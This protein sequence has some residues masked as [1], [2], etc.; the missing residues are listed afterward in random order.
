MFTQSYPW[1][2][3][4]PALAAAL[5]LMWFVQPAMAQETTSAV[6]IEVVGLVQA[7]S[8]NTITV[9]NQ[10]V[11][12]SD[13]E[14]NVSLQVGAAVKVQGALVNG[15]IRAREVNPAEAGIL[16]GEV[17][18]VGVLESFEGGIMMVGGLRIDVQNA[19]LKDAAFVVG[20]LVKVHA[21]FSASAGLWVARE[22]EV[23]TP[24]ADDMDDDDDNDDDLPPG[25]GEFEIVGTLDEVGEGFIVVSGQTISLASGAEIKGALVIGALVKVEGSLTDGAWVARE[26]KR[27]QERDQER[28]NDDMDDDDD[29]NDGDDSSGRS[30]SDDDDDHNGRRSSDDDD[31]DDHGRSGGDDDSSNHGGDDHD[32]DDD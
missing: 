23:F 15:Q 29:N 7:V 13:A 28:H 31:G 16:P 32:D 19:E 21:T 25:A 2:R 22:A 5:V 4:L 24:K 20:E 17:E 9:N 18:I 1:L 3:S 27:A 30:G 26:V 8:Q 11:N 6:E 10:V 12:I 14:I